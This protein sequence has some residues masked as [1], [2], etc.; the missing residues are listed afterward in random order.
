VPDRFVLNLTAL[1]GIERTLRFVAAC[2]ALGLDFSFY[3]GETGVGVA[4]YLHVAAAERV[5]QTPS[6]SLLRWYA[7][8]VIRGGPLVPT[9]GHLSVFEDPGLGVEL[10]REALERASRDFKANGP[11]EQA[12][13][14]PARG[15]YTRP[16]LY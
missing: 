5:L 6:Q 13:I 11:L 16:P 8:D 15:R 10:D 9:E 12:A 1:G 14:D 7:T 3:S 2:E 4:A